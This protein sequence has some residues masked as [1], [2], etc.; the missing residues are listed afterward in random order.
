MGGDPLTVECFTDLFSNKKEHRVA[1]GRF[2]QIRVK[3]APL[4]VMFV[5]ACCVLRGDCGGG[6]T[7]CFQSAYPRQAVELSVSNLLPHH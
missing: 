1:V 7:V 2:M 4:R 3:S 5:I 6:I